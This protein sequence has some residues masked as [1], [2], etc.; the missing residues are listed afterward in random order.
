MNH[1]TADSF[2]VMYSAENF[3]FLP[4]QRIFLLGICCI[5]IFQGKC[6]QPSVMHNENVTHLGHFNQCVCLCVFV[7]A[8]HNKP[9]LF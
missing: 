4:L 8:L 5:I 1:S 7:H 6:L 3:V 9:T 2:G